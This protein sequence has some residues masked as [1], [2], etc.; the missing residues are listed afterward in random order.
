MDLTISQDFAESGDILM[1]RDAELLELA[2]N[3]QLGPYLRFYRWIVP[4]VSLGYHQK[5][6][7]LDEAK[8]NSDH[9]PWV[10]RPTGG[11]AVLHSEEL[12]YAIIIP[13][14]SDARAASAVQEYVGKAIADGLRKLGVN[15]T[16]EERGEPLAALPNRTSCFVRTSKW[17]VGVSG[18]KLVGSA[19][20][21]LG[22]ALLQHGSI[23]EGN[24]H[25][26]IIDLLKVQN[27]SL[28]GALRE[29]LETHS[30]SIFAELGYKI[31]DQEIRKTLA[32]S[33]Q[34]L[35]QDFT[36]EQDVTETIV[37]VN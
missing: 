20:R 27:E 25:L 34:N 18:K 24:D 26:R 17:E 3:D 32:K 19:Q 33:F 35:F 6:E 9:I 16:V 15:A 14:A 36:I 23:L 10:R 37:D 4:T 13:H 28:R 1:R 8:L 21:K 22:H 29:R 31:E 12:T 11:A 30:T 5:Q 2:A 7:L